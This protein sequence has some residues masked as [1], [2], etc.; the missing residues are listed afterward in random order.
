MSSL[1][2]NEIWQIK[3]D[4][5][6][7]EADFQTLTQWISEGRLLPTDQ[8]KKGNLNWNEAG[9]VPIL[10]R[11]FAG[12]TPPPVAAPPVASDNAPSNSNS[13]NNKAAD[14]LINTPQTGEGIAEGAY[15][16][17]T[18]YAPANPQPTATTYNPALIACVNHP[19]MLPRYV[20][21]TCQAYFCQNCAK[22]VGTSGSAIC[23]LCGELC[24]SYQDYA[25][26]VNRQQYQSLPFDFSVL[27]PAI[28]YPLRDQGTLIIG[29][30]VY[31]FLCLAQQIAVFGSGLARAMATAMMFGCMS[32]VIRQVAVGQFNRGF[33]P[34]FTEGSFREQITLPLRLSAA[35]V[36]ITFLPAGLLIGAASYGFIRLVPAGIT[37][38]LSNED[39]EDEPLNEAELDNLVNEQDGAK[40]EE[41]M[42]KLQA[43]SP[44]QDLG[45]RNRPA[46]AK[47]VEPEPFS[48]GFF[49]QFQQFLLAFLPYSYFFVQFIA[50]GGFLFLLIMLAIAWVL[51]YYPMALMVAGFTQ[52]VWSVINPTVGIDTMRRM[53]NT[54]VKAFVIFAVVKL[55]WVVMIGFLTPLQV[56]PLLG[57]VVINVIGGVWGFYVNLVGAYVLGMALYKSADK[58]GIATE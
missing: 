39:D 33:M 38:T 26:R 46:D 24:Q 50:A 15:R 19:D 57:G 22:T 4:N 27:K 10:R 51:V 31:G 8:V 25:Q 48:P 36:L 23:E 52:D 34:D 7:Y 12:E 40:S 44:M 30:I 37:Q 43:Q 3:V 13:I 45:V 32:L 56:V 21:G 5:E 16:K 28:T 11:I 18:N 9:K 2:P 58:L 53:G 55:S 1:N 42:R 41:T 29:L 6:V 20:C 14:N 49:E 54:Y 47:K 35:V 17:Q